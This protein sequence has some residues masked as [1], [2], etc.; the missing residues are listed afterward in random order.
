[1]AI[2]KKIESRFM[3]KWLSS[4][5]PFSQ[6]KIS[7]TRRLSKATSFICPAG[8]LSN[9]LCCFCL[10]KLKTEGFSLFFQLQQFSSFV[11]FFLLYK[12]GGIER[13]VV[14]DKVIKYSG[15]FMGSDGYSF[16][17]TVTPPHS[18]NLFVK[19]RFN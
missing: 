2:P 8:L 15:K 12:D 17:S 7:N 16:W 1:M 14:F 4:M 19:I 9:K 13:L 5:L 3:T 10:N 18:M 6:V 11:L